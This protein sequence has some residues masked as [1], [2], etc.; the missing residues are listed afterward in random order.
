MTKNILTRCQ[1]MQLI[2]GRKSVEVH[3]KCIFH[4]H[5]LSF[6]QFSFNSFNHLIKFLLRQRLHIFKIR[7]PF[8][9]IF[10]QNEKKDWSYSAAVVHGIA[11][12]DVLT[13][14]FILWSFQ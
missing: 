14:C 4:W 10:R 2:T 9:A 8:I 12:H 5:F 3:L 13:M 11:V 6:Q 1:R 7:K